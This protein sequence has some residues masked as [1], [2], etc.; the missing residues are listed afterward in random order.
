MNKLQFLVSFN[1]TKLKEF[2]RYDLN[3]IKA[4]F[5][6]CIYAKC[7]YFVFRKR[8]SD[9]ASLLSTLFKTGWPGSFS[10]AKKIQLDILN[11]LP[12]V[13]LAQYYASIMASVKPMKNTKKFFADP[14]L[15]L[16]GIF[17][18]VRESTPS[19]KGVLIV[20]YSYYFALLFKLFD[21]KAISQR[22]HIVLEPS[23]AGFCDPS[24]L[25][26]T[27]LDEPVFVMT[28]EN[29]DRRFIESLNANL[30][31][32]DIGPNWWVNHEMFDIQEQQQ[33]DI[34]I[35][36]V[37]SWSEF[38]RHAFL[39]SAL[40]KLKNDGYDLKAVMVGYPGDMTLEDIKAQARFCGVADC[41]EFHEWLT[42]EGVSDILKRGKVNILWSRFEGNNRAIIEGMFC[43]T[44]CIMR[45]GHNYGES[46]DY[47]NELTGMFSDEQELPQNIIDIIQGHNK[48]SPREYV[49][50]NHNC[51]RATEILAREIAKIDGIESSNVFAVKINHLHGMKYFWENER[52]RFK[53]DYDQLTRLTN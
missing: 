28:Y 34:D 43:D 26:Y 13:E 40:K 51:I 20:K 4:F 45:K 3:F 7:R 15:F 14:S 21:T 36:S 11:G 24:I 31:P 16:K 33:R 44:P 23:W 9:A 39:F 18:V 49:L 42:P 6:I 41:I 46:Y 12:E 47:I 29:R 19:Q 30:V 17:I 50:K 37:A 10:C 2:L 53:G 25:L 22:Y 52:D 38:K 27:S 8:Y 5:V 32:V 35:V 1:K 48:F